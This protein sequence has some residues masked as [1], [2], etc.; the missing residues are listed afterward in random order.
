MRFPMAGDLDGGRQQSA[1]SSQDL[2]NTQHAHRDHTRFAL[3][4]LPV[5]TA[6][7]PLFSLLLHPSALTLCPSQ[8]SQL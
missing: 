1:Y 3:L 6:N 5:C 7:E 8:T 4:S 2:A